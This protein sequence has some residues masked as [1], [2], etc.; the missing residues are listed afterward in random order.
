MQ[1]SEIRNLQVISTR[2]TFYLGFTLFLKQF[3]IKYQT[4]NYLFIFQSSDQYKKETAVWQL[5]V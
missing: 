1:L 3:P 4:V 5:A 2:S